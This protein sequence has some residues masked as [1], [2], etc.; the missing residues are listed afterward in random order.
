MANKILILPNYTGQSLPTEG[1]DRYDHIFLVTEQQES[2][3]VNVVMQLLQLTSKLSVNIEFM[4]LNYNTESE[5]LFSLAF[6][7]SKM[8]MEDP[9]V[10]ITFITENLAFDSL[11]SVAKKIG[12]NVKR[13]DGFARLSAV[14]PSVDI[15]KTPQPSMIS[16]VA[17]QPKTIEQPIEIPH[18]PE[19]KEEESA[20][21]KNKRLI[22][23]L[24]NGNNAK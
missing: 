14:P 6:Q 18:T 5:L 12:Y 10:Q 4:Q 23:S 11:I 21:N 2:L 15:P 24:L 16:K 22:S 19:V 9:D 3:P 20:G 1:L 7:I 13:A 8:G 17:S